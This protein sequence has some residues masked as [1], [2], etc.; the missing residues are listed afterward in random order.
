M[1]SQLQPALESTTGYWRRSSTFR[2]IGNLKHGLPEWFWACVFI[3][4]LFLGITL[5]AQSS[6][7][8]YVRAFGTVHRVLSWRPWNAAPAPQS[9]LIIVANPDR[10]M[11]VAATL[12]PRGFEPLLAKNLE[13]AGRILAGPLPRLAV[14]DGTVRDAG[15]ISRLLRSR[16]PANRIVILNQA[17]P[18][19]AVGQILLDRL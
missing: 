2:L 13:Q 1:H 18:R 16:L 11:Q 4:V 12:S 6:Q 14:L 15:A 17:T 7:K 8:T 9:V 10:Q 5:S 3:A 19:E